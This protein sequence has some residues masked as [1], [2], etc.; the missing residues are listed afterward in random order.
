LE[1]TATVAEHYQQYAE[2]FPLPV[3]LGLGLLILEMALVNTRLR[4]MP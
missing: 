1:K 3:V 2:R 4:T